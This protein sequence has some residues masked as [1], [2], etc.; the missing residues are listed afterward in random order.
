[1]K[2][3]ATIVHT[4][5][6]TITEQHAAVSGIAPA[7]PKPAAVPVVAKAAPAPAPAPAVLPH[8]GS[9]LPL[10]GLLGLLALAV[11][12]GIGIIRRF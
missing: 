10:A 2:V 5:E 1:M 8:T 12:A 6:E 7:K 3:S 9:S 11:S 4:S